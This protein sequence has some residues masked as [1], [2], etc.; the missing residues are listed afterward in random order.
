MRPA[1]FDSPDSLIPRHTLETYELADA[2]WRPLAIFRE[3]DTVGV[4]PFDQIVI[5]LADLW[6]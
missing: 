6:S 2:K 5:Y 1:T 4:A 3:N